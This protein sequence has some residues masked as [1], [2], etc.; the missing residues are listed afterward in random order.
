MKE[1]GRG[2]ERMRHRT[3]KQSETEAEREPQTVGE[4]ERNIEGN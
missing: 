1:R 4:I 3:G 2:G